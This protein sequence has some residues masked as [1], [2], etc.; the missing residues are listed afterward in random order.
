MKISKWYMALL[1]LISSL[2]LTEWFN[3]FG[4]A[5]LALV[6]IGSTVLVLAFKKEVIKINY[7]VLVIMYLFM[8]F[9]ALSA[10]F[11][12]D[13]KLIIN[14]TVIFFLYVST[15]IVIPT[16]NKIGQDVIVKSALISNLPI[17]LIPIIVY[18]FNTTPYRGIFYNP[19]A[20][21]T[22]S[23]TIF[24]V[25]LSK[26]F[27]NI[28]LQLFSKKSNKLKT[29]KL[30]AYSLSMIYLVVLSGSRTSVL[31]ALIL[32]IA[33]VLVISFK[34]INNG[35]LFGLIR[36]AL[37][38]SII[39]LG[40]I[41][42]SKVSGLYDYLYLNVI[43]KFELKYQRGDV[44]ANRGEVWRQTFS[45]AKILGN[46]SEYFTSSTSIS[47]HNTFI[48]VL[49]EY[50]WLPLG[51]FV[52]LLMVFIF[53]SAKYTS[54]ADRYSYLPLMITLSFVSMSMA[55]NMMFKLSMLM[56]FFCVG[57]I[58]ND[59]RVCVPEPSKYIYKKKKKNC[60]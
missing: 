6:L 19:N 2:Y 55:E 51:L 43:Y 46:G 38:M 8:L 58:K 36:G 34:L 12:T 15:F 22:I 10:L 1:F 44:L 50:G 39:G 32:I 17:L 13:P 40:S 33:G 16:F 29:F 24:A 7:S 45:D 35:R 11:N 53:K 49:G 25:F 56:M 14:T 5:S 28:E 54:S 52:L 60:T 18:G 27:K 42:F 59:S 20:M 30:I 9:G 41:I 31:T 47:A 23:V 57:L 37:L 48:N 26:I 3:Q 4:S 21:G